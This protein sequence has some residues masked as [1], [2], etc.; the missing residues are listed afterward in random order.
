MIARVISDYDC[1]NPSLLY[2]ERAGSE[3]LTD[4]GDTPYS[5]FFQA[6]G[7]QQPRQSLSPPVRLGVYVDYPPG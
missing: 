7:N 1:R 3:V 5:L 6:P 2:R 4:L